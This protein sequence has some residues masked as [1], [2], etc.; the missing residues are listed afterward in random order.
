MKQIDVY[1]IEYEALT[2]YAEEHDT[3]VAEVIYELVD[4]FLDEIEM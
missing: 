3:M 4:N 1:D 2:K